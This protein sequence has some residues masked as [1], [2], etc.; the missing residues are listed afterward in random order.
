MGKVIVPNGVTGGDGITGGGTGVT[1]GVGVGSGVGVGVTVVAGTGF[2]GG[3]IDTGGSTGVGGVI[4]GA[5]GRLSQEN[6]R[7]HNVGL[8][9]GIQWL[10]NEL[11]PR[12]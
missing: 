10:L 4:T 2:C 12:L 8:G 6:K 11:L 9:L 7:S 3:V 5:G 1:G